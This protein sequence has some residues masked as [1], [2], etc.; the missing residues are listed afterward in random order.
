MNDHDPTARDVLER[1]TPAELP[2]GPDWSDVARRANRGRRRRLL[3][4]A[5]PAV[6]VAAF[7]AVLTVLVVQAGPTSAPTQPGISQT[8]FGDLA[9]QA[10]AFRGE[11]PPAVRKAFDTYLPS[12]AV[13]E[14]RSLRGP[15]E[16]ASPD[17]PV[18]VW[19]QTGRFPTGTPGPASFPWYVFEFG[20]AAA[21]PWG[22]RANGDECRPR[23][24]GDVAICDAGH[25]IYGGV[26]ERVDHA[27]LVYADGTRR[28]VAL[29]GGW[30]A[31][32]PDPT[33]S[34][35]PEGVV[36]YDAAGAQ[37]GWT[38]MS[39]LSFRTPWQPRP[40][41]P[42][43]RGQFGVLRHAAVTD[44]TGIDNINPQVPVRRVRVVGDWSIY[45][46]APDDSP[47]V[48]I[49]PQNP[50]A[51]PPNWAVFPACF[52]FGAAVRGEASFQPMANNYNLDGENPK[53]AMR[54]VGPVVGI[55][56][57][58]FVEARIGAT[59]AKITNNAYVIDAPAHPLTVTLIRSD[60]SAIQASVSDFRGTSAT[61]S[62]SQTQ[63]VP[64]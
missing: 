13:W 41:D 56:P 15:L 20:D 9:R 35:A 44:L 11:L 19:E 27:D 36:V 34:R 26:S 23:A 28:P 63:P 38:R 55:A 39:G 21:E 47:D 37:L 52:A 33:K 22:I 7:G 29:G 30:F 51:S 12:G 48:C 59:T 46:Q 42:G 24:S 40:F 2:G 61:N 45:V 43:L 57:D 1:H 54:S 10:P 32:L 4:Q 64:D 18:R 14:P 6:A 5:V 50:K 62:D 60:G 53:R 49:V 3:K 25:W 58:G 8:A 31:V 17:G 16:L